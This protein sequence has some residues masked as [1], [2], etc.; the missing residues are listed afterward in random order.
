MAIQTKTITNR[1]ICRNAHERTML[2]VENDSRHIAV[3][4]QGARDRNQ[5]M[6]KAPTVKVGQQIDL[7]V[8]IMI[9]TNA[10][11]PS[12]PIEATIRFLNFVRE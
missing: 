3:I 8:L 5:R 2:M 11:T 12:S 10:G 9:A 4:D 1:I 7:V 6:L